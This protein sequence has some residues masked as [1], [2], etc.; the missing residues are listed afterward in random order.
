MLKLTLSGEKSGCDRSLHLSLLLPQPF[1]HPPFICSLSCKWKIKPLWPWNPHVKDGETNL[2]EFLKCLDGSELLCPFLVPH[3]RMFLVPLK[4]I[5][6]MKIMLVFWCNYTCGTMCNCGAQ[7]VVS[8][9][10]FVLNSCT[11]CI[12][13]V[14]TYKLIIPSFGSE[15]PQC[16]VF[17]TSQ[18]ML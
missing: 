14:H 3:S 6:W 15:Q 16:L 2:S 11:M 7:R 13:G 8:T 1:L 18:T 4:N 9:Y 5:I 17:L 10:S 12:I